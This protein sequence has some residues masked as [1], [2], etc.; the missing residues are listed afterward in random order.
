MNM[1][2]IISISLIITLIFASCQKN[3]DLNIPT[4]QSK[5]VVNGEFNTDQNLAVE[6]SKSV[7][8]TQDFDTNGLVIDNAK[9]LFFEDNLLLGQ[10]TFVGGQ[11]VYN[12]KPIANKIYSVQVDVNTYSTIGAKVQMPN[13][14][15]FT[16]QYIDSIGADK[17]GYRIGGLKMSIVDDGSQKNF[18]QLLIKYYDQPIQ[19]WFN[20]DI[21]SNDQIFINTKQKD[22]SYIFNDLTFNGTTKNISLNIEYQY[23]TSTPKFEIIIKSI[24]SEYYTY[25]QQIQ[26][27]NQT[28]RGLVDNPVIIKSNVT[29]GLGM[30]GAVSGKSVKIP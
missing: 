26:E 7:G 14:V 28:G 13:P 5:I 3:I 2:K 12:K 20:Y 4:N 1:K 15:G 21:I 9:V 18:Y 22:G 19:Q 10:A 27:F 29:N 8:L 24:D 6:V 25:L 30:V 11:Y 23:T 16:T 17:D